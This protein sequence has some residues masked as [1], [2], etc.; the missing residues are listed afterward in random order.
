MRVP[1]KLIATAAVAAQLGPRRVGAWEW[2]KAYLALALRNAQAAHLDNH[3]TD[4]IR[5]S[6]RI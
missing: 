1:G 3:I 5:L 6:A 2:G 4:T